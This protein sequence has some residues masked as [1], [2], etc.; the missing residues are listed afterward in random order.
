MSPGCVVECKL[1]RSSYLT[2]KL[3]MGGHYYVVESTV[4]VGTVWFVIACCD[5]TD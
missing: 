4:I 5:V 3:I 2:W 1:C